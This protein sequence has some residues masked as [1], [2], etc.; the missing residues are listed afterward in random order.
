[1]ERFAALASLLSQQA[2]AGTPRG[3]RD[4]SHVVCVSFV[5]LS[6]GRQA[7]ASG[8]EIFFEVFVFLEIS[9][10]PI[11]IDTAPRTTLRRIAPPI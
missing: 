10:A 2:R 5:G 1:M 7:D 8:T 11:N 6:D 3:A 9:Q 4:T